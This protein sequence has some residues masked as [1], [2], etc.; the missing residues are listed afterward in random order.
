MLE[1]SCDDCKN[2]Q[3]AHELQGQVA[4]FSLLWSCFALLLS[5]RGADRTVRIWE[6]GSGKEVQRL[7][8]PPKGSWCVAWSPGSR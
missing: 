3:G 4:S 1:R 2:A 6:V 8:G 5:A 7:P